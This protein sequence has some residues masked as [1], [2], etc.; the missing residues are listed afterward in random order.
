MGIEHHFDMWN[1]FICAR[2]QQGLD[3]EMVAL[4]S[5]DI[6]VQ[7]GPGVDP[8]FHLPMSDPPIRWQKIWF[9][10]RIAA[11]SPIPSGSATC[12][13][14]LRVVAPSPGP[15]GGYGVAQTDLR[16]LQTLRE[17]IQRLL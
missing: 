15:T 9:F 17:V 14:C 2:L 7:S 4:G 3:A 5:V 8:Y 6:L 10:L 16:R 12:S 13:L 1:Y 11:L